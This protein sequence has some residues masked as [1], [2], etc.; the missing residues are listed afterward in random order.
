MRNPSTAIAG[1]LN[2]LGWHQT[3]PQRPYAKN[4]LNQSDKTELKFQTRLY[5]SR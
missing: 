1:I 2:G 4:R 5:Q 3:P